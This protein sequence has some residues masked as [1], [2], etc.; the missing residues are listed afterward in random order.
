[1]HVVAIKKDVVEKNP[2]LIEAVFNAYSQ[3][4]QSAYDYLTKSAWYKTTL[5]WVSQELED[6]RALMGKN[7]WTYGIESNRKTL[8]TFFRYSYEQG[9]CSR[10]LTIEELFLPES[11]KFTE[12]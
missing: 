11:L 8:D 3:A 1:M 9:L 2:W 7:F 5:P 12:S 4:K 10:K 6:T